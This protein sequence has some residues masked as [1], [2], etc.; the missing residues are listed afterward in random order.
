MAVSHRE[1]TVDLNRVLQA[2]AMISKQN[3][4]FL[5]AQY[6]PRVNNVSVK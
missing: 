4:I 3:N 2:P 5:A 1:E 6:L